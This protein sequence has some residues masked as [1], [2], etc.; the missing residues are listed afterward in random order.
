MHAMRSTRQESVASQHFSLNYVHKL[1]PHHRCRRDFDKP[2][3]FVI[4]PTTIPQ[5]EPKSS[6]IDGNNQF[7]TNSGKLNQ[8]SSGNGCIPPGE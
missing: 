4:L 5:H 1:A 6:K 2:F 3:L 8:T 7:D